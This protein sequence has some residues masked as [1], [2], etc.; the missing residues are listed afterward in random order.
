MELNKKIN[1]VNDKEDEKSFYERLSYYVGNAESRLFHVTSEKALKT[2][3]NKDIT[4]IKKIRDRGDRILAK[5]HQGYH[6]IHDED[7]LLELAKN[8]SIKEIIIEKITG[9]E[10]QR[11]KLVSDLNG[12]NK[13]SIDQLKGKEY[14]QL[15]YSR[16]IIKDISKKIITENFYRAKNHNELHSLGR[17]FEKHLENG[18]NTFGVFSLEEQQTSVETIIG[19]M[20]YFNYYRHKGVLV[21]MEQEELKLLKSVFPFF[22]YQSESSILD[23]EID[24]FR[25]LD[26]EI[27]TF[28]DLHFLSEDTNANAKETAKYLKLKSDILFVQVPGLGKI[29]SKKQIYFPLIDTLD[30]ISLIANKDELS[31]KE[32]TKTRDFFSL[33]DVDINGLILN[34]R[35][36]D[37][38]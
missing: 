27:V 22:K 14:N 6:I 13:D 21:A 36:E 20:T 9:D 8:D 4:L 30:N 11:V 17:Q 10:V 25:Y 24:C 38:C 15:K 18:L 33:Y 7:K 2:I 29:E 12:F 19:L 3:T 23:I 28:E 16:H 5:D 26:N 37:E 35:G 32:I 31:F 1:L 34:K